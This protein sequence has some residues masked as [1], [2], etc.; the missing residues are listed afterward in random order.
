MTKKDVKPQ[1]NFYAIIPASVRYHK[2]LKAN[3]KLMYA[4]ITALSNAYGYCWAENKYFAELYNVHKVTVSNWISNLEKL[5]FI[6][7]ELEYIKGTKQVSRRL[8]YVDTNP[9]N[10]ITNRPIKEKT[11]RP[12]NEITKEEL[13]NTSINNTRVNNTQRDKDLEYLVQ[14]YQDMGYGSISPSAYMTF[15]KL[16]DKGFTAEA[17][18]RAYQ[19]ASDVNRKHQAYING[20]LRKWEEA[21]IKTVEQIEEN[22][23][24]F[25]EK[26]EVKKK[27]YDPLAKWRDENEEVEYI[28]NENDPLAKWR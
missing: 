15:E 26:A 19:I 24:K 25:R 21:G 1:P 7:T 2:E 28:E 14:R 27:A 3:E 4:E 9:I 11:N 12:I 13:N 18:E 22:E 20:I 23:S 8:I 5:G 10:E 17:I 6:K 16:L